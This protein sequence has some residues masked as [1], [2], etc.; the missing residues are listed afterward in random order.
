VDIYLEIGGRRVFAVA[1]EWPG[2]CRSGRDE[3]AAIEALLAYGERYRAAV[4]A[5]GNGLDLPASSTGVSIV[6]RVKGGAG[7][8]FGVPV[9]VTSFDEAAVSDADLERLIALHRACWQTFERVAGRAAGHELLPAGPRGG[10]R[11]VAKIRLH[12]SESEAAY[13]TNIGIRYRGDD[14]PAALREAFVAALRERA[15]GR[16]PEV[17][18]RGGRRSPARYAVRRSCWH[19][20]DHAWEIADRLPAG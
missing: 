19:L 13:I 3:A 11:S 2:W 20:L 18:P 16:L 17:G 9:V 4:G 15:A 10:G 12:V 6:E 14:E 1:V 8:D 7:T 5:A